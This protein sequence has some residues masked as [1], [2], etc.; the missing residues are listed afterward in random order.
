MNRKLAPISL[1]DVAAQQAWLEDEAAKGRFL[2]A[3]R[4][5][6]FPSVS[7][8]EGPPRAVRYRLEPLGRKEDG[9]DGERREVYAALGWDY[10]CTVKGAFHIWRCGDP[11]SAE[12]DTDPVV[13]G[14]AYDLQCRRL[15]RTELFC[16]AVLLLPALLAL[17]FQV[18]MGGGYLV[19]LAESWS[20]LWEAL[21]LLAALVFAVTQELYWTWSFRRFVRTLKTGIPMPQRR[22][23]RLS[24]LLAAAALAVYVLFLVSRCAALFRPSTRPFTPVPEGAPCVAAEQLD[25][26]AETEEPLAIRWRN[27]LTPEQWWVVEPPGYE[28]RYYRLASSVLA[29]PLE[30]SLL[31][32]FR[33]RGVTLAPAACGGL[34]SAWLGGNDRTQYLLAC[35]GGQVLWAAVPLEADLA[36]NL[37]AYAA[38]LAE[39]R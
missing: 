10:V 5:G 21:A 32:Q 11:E 36:G 25:P 4:S 27:W 31:A 15:R 24:H 17:F 18:S 14:S 6:V 9:P 33:Q 38:I 35:R 20:P 26:A 13:R 1:Y 34:D 37:D 23:Y 22:P 29:E 28:S 8:T 2:S 16:G 39:R 7:F 19:G 12:L 30:E 3:Y